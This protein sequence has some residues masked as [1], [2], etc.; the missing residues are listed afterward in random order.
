MLKVTVSIVPGGLGA[1]RKLG[2][3]FITNVAGGAL[4]NYKCF[5]TADDSVSTHVDIKRYP[6]WAAP[7][8]DLVARAIAKALSGKERLPP[9]PSQVKVPIR[10]DAATGLQYV[11][12]EDIPEPAKTAFSRRTRGSTAPVI[13]GERDCVYPGDWLRFIELRR[14]TKV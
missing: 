11:R 1:E 6:R 8:W 9:R 14:R 5:L 2:E 10:T 4:A 3:L 12:M 7:V 13:P